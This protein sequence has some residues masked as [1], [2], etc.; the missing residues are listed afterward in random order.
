MRAGL[1]LV[2]VGLNVTRR[3]LLPKAR[4]E[5]HLSSMPRTTLR[6][7]LAACSAPYFD[8]CQKHESADSC[9]LHDPLA[10]GAAIDPG[11]VATEV[12]ECDVI[13]RP[14]L[15]RGMMLVDRGEP[16]SE[17]PTARVATDVNSPKFLDLFLETVCAA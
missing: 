6:S 15:T 9:A 5:R 13:D 3:A 4:F 17:T 1:P 8:F 14:G 2:I 16:G 11:L 12:L 7:F 10:V